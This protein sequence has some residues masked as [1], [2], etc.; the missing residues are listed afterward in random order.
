M[1][2]HRNLFTEALKKYWIQQRD[3]RDKKEFGVR[4]REDLEKALFAQIGQNEAA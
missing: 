2:F 4:S 3:L 1:S